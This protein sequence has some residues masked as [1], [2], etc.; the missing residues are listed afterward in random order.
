MRAGWQWF[1]EGPV[2]NFDCDLWLETPDSEDS[3][4]SYTYRVEAMT[5]PPE[6]EAER[7]PLRTDFPYRYNKHPTY[8]RVDESNGLSPTIEEEILDRIWLY[9]LLGVAEVE[10]IVD[11]LAM[12]MKELSNLSSSKSFSMLLCAHAF[13]SRASSKRAS[14]QR[15]NLRCRCDRQTNS[16]CIGAAR[17]RG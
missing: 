6:V 1:Y 9:L 14:R 11:T 3:P 15:L 5:E 8:I 13:I 16:S 4:A 7:K 12:I 17:A 2:F 10:D